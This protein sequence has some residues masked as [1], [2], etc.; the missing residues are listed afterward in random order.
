MQTFS[1][2]HA[3]PDKVQDGRTCRIQI[4]DLVLVVIVISIY[5]SLFVYCLKKSDTREFFINSMLGLILGAVFEIFDAMRLTRNLPISVV[6][7]RS[8]GLRWHVLT[9]SIGLIAFAL[10]VWRLFGNVGGIFWGWY[11]ARI[12]RHLMEGI[13]F[14]GVRCGANGV[15]IPL[16]GFCRWP[17]VRVSIDEHNLLLTLSPQ[18]RWLPLTVLSCIPQESLNELKALAASRI[19]GGAFGSNRDCDGRVD[20]SRDI[21]SPPAPSPG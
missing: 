12:V 17:S 9:H 10:L 20:L 13:V 18:D 11:G 14:S 1:D 2:A 19:T 4:V 5:I 7:C 16:C 8:R 21:T 15:V 6:R 3:P